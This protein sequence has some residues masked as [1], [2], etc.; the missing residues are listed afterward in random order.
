MTDSVD[1]LAA[2]PTFVVVAA[3]VVGRRRGLVTGRANVAFHLVCSTAGLYGL[4]VGNVAA[5]T[6]LAVAQ[7]VWWLRAGIDAGPVALTSSTATS[8]VAAGWCTGWEPA[9]AVVV[10]VADTLPAVAPAGVVAVLAAVAVVSVRFGQPHSLRRA[11]RQA[12]KGRIPQRRRDPARTFPEAWRRPLMAAQR[13]ACYLCGRRMVG[14]GRKRRPELDHVVAH[15]RGG[16]TTR[17][18]CLLACSRCNKIKSD[19][20]LLAARALIMARTGRW[21]FRRRPSQARIE[22]AF[23]RAGVSQ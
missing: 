18:N 5:A 17:A 3:A 21:A 13:G 22:R 4:W 11:A 16:R 20:G 15:A 23:R 6:V 10:V 8:V 14:G 9:S 7:V 12:A 19:R 2:L 1:L